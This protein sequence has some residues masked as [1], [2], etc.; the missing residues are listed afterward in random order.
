[1]LW[2]SNFVV[3]CFHPRFL[4]ETHNTK[5]AFMRTI[6]IIVVVFILGIFGYTIFNSHAKQW[7]K[8]AKTAVTDSTS[9]SH[10][11]GM[12]EEA[13]SKAEVE[14]KKRYTDV[15]NVN[16]EVAKL[17]PVVQK[18]KAALAKEEKILKRAQELLKHNKQ[19][20]AVLVG[21]VSYAWDAVNGDTLNRVSNCKALQANIQNN[22][23]ALNRL[24][25]AYNDGMEMIRQKRDE[26]KKKQMEFEAEKAEL[27]ALRAQAYVDQVVGKIYS[28]GD[29][30]IELGEAREAFERRL[31]A[32]RANAQYDQEIASRSSAVS[33][34]NTELGLPTETAVDAIESYFKVTSES[35][36]ANSSTGVG[37]ALEKLEEKKEL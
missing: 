16:L 26:L 31:N 15:Y 19:G 29:I 30:K 3:C 5:G 17:E 34:W 35:V 37:E 21:F 32:L 11:I 23:Q 7:L 22:E 28:A 1:M 25:A 8:D 24:K 6:A 14:L 33:T 27:A 10:V 9:D 2:E 20:S 36:P 12:T 18:H 13:M 4:R